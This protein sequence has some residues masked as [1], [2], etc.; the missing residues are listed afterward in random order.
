M[1]QEFAAGNLK[2]K[3]ND[4]YCRDK[5]EEAV[6]QILANLARI[7]Y[8]ALQEIPQ[9]EAGREARQEG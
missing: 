1:V 8:P 6:R 7:A 9:E 3:I 4:E 5:T 2:I